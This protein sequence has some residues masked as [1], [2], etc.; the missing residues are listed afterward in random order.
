MWTTKSLAVTS[1]LYG[2]LY[3]LSN[4]SRAYHRN[5]KSA[6][7]IAATVL[8]APST[9]ELH[10]LLLLWDRVWR[11]TWV[12]FYYNQM[13]ALPLDHRGMFII[14]D[15]GGGGQIRGGAQKVSPPLRGGGGSWKFWGWSGGGVIKVWP[16]GR[17]EFFWRV[18]HGYIIRGQNILS[19]WCWDGDRPM[20]NT[21]EH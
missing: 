2:C 9:I 4:I 12:F 15:G 11:V 16:S 17:V 13:S 18:A 3:H 6:V 7:I 19:Q 20:Q 5:S 1:I 8:G 14:Y 21:R 10:V